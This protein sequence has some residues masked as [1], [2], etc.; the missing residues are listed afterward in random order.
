VSK[1][2]G[3]SIMIA[4]R[5]EPAIVL[6]LDELVRRAQQPRPGYRRASRSD[7]LR[8]LVL[9]AAAADDRDQQGRQ[10]TLT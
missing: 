3:S 4:F 8:A 2:S 1:K 5:S 9:Q 7:V 10:P 6:A